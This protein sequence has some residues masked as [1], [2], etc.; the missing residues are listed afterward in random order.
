MWD[1]S[2]PEIHPESSDAYAFRP[3]SGRASVVVP[4]APTPTG[5]YDNTDDEVETPF[6]HATG[7]VESSRASTTADSPRA[8]M[9]QVWGAGPRQSSIG[10]DGDNTH[11]VRW[12][13]SVSGVSESHLW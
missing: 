4:H 13:G 12:R 1:L 10:I 7:D 11:A 8:S 5:A 2:S 6:E 9:Q 3:A